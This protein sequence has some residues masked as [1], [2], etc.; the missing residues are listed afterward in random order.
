MRL[1]EKVGRTIAKAI[2]YRMFSFLITLTLAYM[3]TGDLAS[4]S[5][6]SVS[7]HLI[8]TCWYLVHERIWLAMP[9]GVFCEPTA[10]TTKCRKC[11]LLLKEG[12]SCES[13]DGVARR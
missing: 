9:W 12:E 7:L 5:M 8:L 1:N 13:A 2:T 3:A 6:F 10:L 4:S 11:H